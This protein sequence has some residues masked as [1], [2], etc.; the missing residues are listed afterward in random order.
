M[1][2]YRAPK[3]A[4][5]T[6]T[7]VRTGRQAVRMPARKDVILRAEA[8]SAGRQLTK[9][10]FE[11]LHVEFPEQNLKKMFVLHQLRLFREQK[12]EGKTMTE[13]QWSRQRKL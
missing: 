9:A 7:F 11:Q 8:L 2:V 10:G 6:P 1:K 12:A 5:L 13:M 4:S 3:R